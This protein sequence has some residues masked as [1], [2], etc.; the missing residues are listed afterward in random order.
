MKKS[1]KRKVI[2]QKYRQGLI[3]EQ[4]FNEINNDI[5]KHLENKSRKN[6]FLIQEMI[7]N[8]EDLGLEVSFS[9]Q[10]IRSKLSTFFN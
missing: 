8:R 10:Q 7:A 6:E 1:D 5:E 4:L 9:E 3:P 2:D